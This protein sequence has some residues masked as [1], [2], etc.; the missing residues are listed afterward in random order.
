MGS[1]EHSLRVQGSGPSST[2]RRTYLYQVAKRWLVYA[3]PKVDFES[4]PAKDGLVQVLDPDNKEE[5]LTLKVSDHDCD[6]LDDWIQASGYRSD[7]VYKVHNKV[8]D[9]PVWVEATKDVAVPFEWEFDDPI[10]VVG[11]RPLEPPESPKS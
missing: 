3:F 11:R 9:A 8:I 4:G 6:D 5:V 2:E 10:E 7:W 1:Q